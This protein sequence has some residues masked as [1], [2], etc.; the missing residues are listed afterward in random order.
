MKCDGSTEVSE[1][2]PLRAELESENKSE[3]GIEHG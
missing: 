3:E 1:N 2:W